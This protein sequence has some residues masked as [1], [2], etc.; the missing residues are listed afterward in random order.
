MP[1]SDTG[2]PFGLRADGTPRKRPGWAPNDPRRRRPEPDNIT[3]SNASS[4]APPGVPPSLEELKAIRTKPTEDRPPG[5]P[6]GGPRLV[7]KPAVEQD[8]PPFRAGPI[9]KGMNRLY[10]K[11]GKFLRVIDPQIGGVLVA[12]TRKESDDDTT[13]GEAWEELAKT[14]P[15]V[16][17][18]LLKLIE[19]GALGT[20]IAVHA[21]LILAILMKDR[22][23][24]FI[25]FARIIEA[26][27][28]DD[29][30]EFDTDGQAPPAPGMPFGLRPE[31]VQ[32]MMSTFD[33]GLLAGMMQN[34]N[35][36][37]ANPAR[38]ETVQP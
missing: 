5:R 16:R 20:L 19:R 35:P 34:M 6:K 29:D 37:G 28:S 32:Q 18:F 24:R 8:I 22:I 23:R 26:M 1:A 9:A 3:D 25:P 12:M 4:D 15:R 21:P 30:T 36:N 14:N 38:T 33:T 27:T 17:V 31:D 7:T 11:A 2:T 10:T 13:V